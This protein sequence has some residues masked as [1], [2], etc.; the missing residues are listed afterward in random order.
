MR[1]HVSNSVQCSKGLVPELSVPEYHILLVV[2][3]SRDSIDE[4]NE[5]SSTILMLPDNC[6]S[7]E[8]SRSSDKQALIVHVV[9]KE[10]RQRSGTTTYTC[11]Y[12]CICTCMFVI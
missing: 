6:E 8:L 5:M 3:R 9:L 2:L 7:M 11:T 10:T 1:T 12:T 4:R